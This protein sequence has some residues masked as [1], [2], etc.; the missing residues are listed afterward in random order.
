MK[1]SFD[2]IWDKV[3]VPLKGKTI[4][5]LDENKANTIVDVNADFLE[6]DSINESASQKI[7]KEVFEILYNYIMKNGEITRIYINEKLPERYSSI[8]CTVLAKAPNI[9]YDVKPIRLYK[10]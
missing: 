3:I 2:Q 10:K 8:I 5:T 4:Y 6:R 9:C 7:P 1:I